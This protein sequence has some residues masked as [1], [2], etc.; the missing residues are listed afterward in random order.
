M[1]PNPTGPGSLEEEEVRTQTP[2]G[3]ALR[4]HGEQTG[5]YTP[6]RE[7]LGG[8]SPA[9]PWGSDSGLQD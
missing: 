6:R 9:H 2:R 7:A 5:V 8:G 3:T 4:G 1:G